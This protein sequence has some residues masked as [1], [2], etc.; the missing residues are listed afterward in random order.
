MK[1]IETR[2]FVLRKFFEDEDENQ[3]S[4]FVA[5]NELV[6][7]LDTEEANILRR[8]FNVL[9]AD[10]KNEPQKQVACDEDE[11]GFAQLVAQSDFEH[12]GD[13]NTYH[14]KIDRIEDR[15][16]QTGKDER[17]YEPVVRRL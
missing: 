14:Q 5:K 2:F 6:S 8:E 4:V 3:G 10:K 15:S 9:L 11:I 17:E 16:C 1:L 13:E 7:I 12:L